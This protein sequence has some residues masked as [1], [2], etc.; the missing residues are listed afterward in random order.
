M[1][2]TRARRL[3][4]AAAAA[5][6]LATDLAHEALEP[7]P[8]HHLRS[9]GALVA[10]VALAALVL[11][12]VPRVASRAAT[13]GAGVAAGGA[14]GMALSGLVWSNGVPD[15]LVGGGYAFNL[16]DVAIVLGDV[17]LLVAVAGHAWDNRR[18]L[19]RAV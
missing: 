8:Y 17:L 5:L 10:M 18:A 7:T 16:G 15:P 2:T 3:V 6:V 1:E 19:H 11:A 12:F 9:P 4:A 14:L 13:L